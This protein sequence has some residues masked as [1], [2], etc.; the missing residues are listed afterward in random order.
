MSQI[1]EL[2]SKTGS[3]IGTLIVGEGGFGC[4]GCLGGLATI[5][6]FVYFLS[7][8]TDEVDKKNSAPTP[9]QIV[10]IK[11]DQDLL[12]KNGIINCNEL[13]PDAAYYNQ[14]VVIANQT[15]YIMYCTSGYQRCCFKSGY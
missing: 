7:L 5:F 4:L 11:Q 12:E 10:Q 14:R 2:F 8:I 6:F 3:K 15:H 9:Q 13:P 1:I